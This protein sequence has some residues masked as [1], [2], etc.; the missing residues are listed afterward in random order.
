MHKILLSFVSAITLMT[1]LSATRS[2]R[3]IK[4]NFKRSKQKI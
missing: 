2:Y 4:Q 3:Q 1:T